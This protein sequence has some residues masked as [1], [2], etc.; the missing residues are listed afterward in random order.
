MPKNGR[1]RL[2]V[3]VNAELCDKNAGRRLN[4]R[5]RLILRKSFPMFHEKPNYF[6]KIVYGLEYSGRWDGEMSYFIGSITVCSEMMISGW[7][8]LYLPEG[9]GFCFFNFLICF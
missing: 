9:V 5:A 4:Q 8:G 1:R 6:E 7:D 3:W 2:P